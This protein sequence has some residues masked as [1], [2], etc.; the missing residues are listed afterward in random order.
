MGSLRLLQRGSLLDTLAPFILIPDQLN[1]YVNSETGNDNNDGLTSGVALETIMAAINK[2]PA[3]SNGAT[4]TITGSFKEI[5]YIIEK[6][7]V[8]NKQIQIVGTTVTLDTGTLTGSASYHYLTDSAKSWGTDE[9]KGKFCKIT[10][11]TYSN[12]VFPIMGNTADTLDVVYTGVNVAI[13][14]TYEIFEP[15]ATIDGENTR[16]TC[17]YAKGGSIV[18]TL[19]NLNIINSTIGTRAEDGIVLLHDSCYFETHATY[20][21]YS[22]NANRTDHQ[23]CY[24][25]GAATET[26]GV[27]GTQ[28]PQHFKYC[29]FDG[30][31]KSNGQAIQYY[32]S[33]SSAEYCSFYNCTRGVMGMGSG[34]I[35]LPYNLYKNCSYGIYGQF[36]ACIYSLSNIFDTCSEGI[37][38]EL[39]AEI[40]SDANTFTSVTIPLRRKLGGRI[41]VLNAV[42]SITTNLLEAEY[43]SAWTACTEGSG[44]NF[45][46]GF[47]FTPKRV[48]V[49]YS[50]DGSGSM[51]Y[52]DNTI[53]Q[54]GD[55]YIGITPEQTGY[56]KVR[57]F[58]E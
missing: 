19:K 24:F 14:S 23:S 54:A 20:A 44:R 43:E 45:A 41:Y 35:K 33:R 58:M 47:G 26:Y 37:R 46:H 39:F 49:L 56:Y 29:G 2:I 57:A 28:S 55:T 1:L 15:A 50:T 3:T 4:I 18:A 32:I 5:V 7:I 30:Y 16:S 48:D 9:H 6:L 27:Y 51:V 22:A 42:G 36:G 40:Y 53:W 34:Y 52:H 11:G 12:Y 38:S 13:G 21:T 10:S 31:T 8:S 17:V 25:K